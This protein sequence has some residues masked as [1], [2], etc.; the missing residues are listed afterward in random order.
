MRPKRSD[1][2]YWTGTRN[3][4]HIQYERDLEDYI[5]DLENEIHQL[6]ASDGKKQ[7]LGEVFSNKAQLADFI[8]V[9]IPIYVKPKI[10]AKTTFV[11]VF[12]SENA[13]RAVVE[14]LT[15]RIWDELY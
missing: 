4:N 10:K 3:F 14:K 5:I 6:R 2:K 9:N 12:T 1:N 15:D 8:G 13:L 7:L 11:S